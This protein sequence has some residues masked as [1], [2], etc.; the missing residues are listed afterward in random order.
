MLL[1]TANFEIETV[2][3][4]REYMAV[5]TSNLTGNI[6]NGQLGIGKYDEHSY[7]PSH[8][9]HFNTGLK[10]GIWHAGKLFIGTDEG[11]LLWYNQSLELQ[12]SCHIHQDM[13]T[14]L[15]KKGRNLLSSDSYE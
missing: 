12:K 1:W 6:W 14:A 8:T 9:L 10:Q 11:Q 2:S 13:V 4:Q 5:L 15:S 7:T 3:V